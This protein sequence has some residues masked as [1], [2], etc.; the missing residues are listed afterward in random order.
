MAMVMTQHYLAGEL[1]VL[2]EQLHDAAADQPQVGDLERLRHTAETV[3]VAA[4]GPVIAR[5]LRVSE[6]LCWECLTPGDVAT[7]ERLSTAAR[8]LRE[9]AVC[10]GLAPDR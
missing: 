4:L 8:Q 2:L 10:A 7:F 9:F 3:P 6:T 1:S 5:A